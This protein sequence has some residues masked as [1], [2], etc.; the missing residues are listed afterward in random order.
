MATV[1]KMAWRSIWRNKRRTIISLISIAFGLGLAIFFIT[2]A[3]GAYYQVVRDAVKMQ[4]GYITIEHKGYLDAPAVDMFVS[5]PESILEPVRKLNLIENIKL[6]IVGGGVAKSGSGSVGVSFLGV[7]P[8]REVK[9][10]P[11]AKKIIDGQFL[12][13]EDGNLIIVGAVLAKRLKLQIGKK[14]V[15]STNDINGELVEELCRVKGIFKTGSDETDGQ[16]VL[17]PIGFARKLTS[18]PENAATQIGLMLRN[19]DQLKLAHAKVSKLVA[20]DQIEVLT[21]N[22]V[23]P[24]LAAYIKMDRTSGYIFY[25]IIFALVL[26]SIFNTI[27]M[28]VMERKHEFAIFLAI[29]TSPRQLEAQVVMESAYLGLLGSLLG[30]LIGYLISNY[31]AVNGWDLSG[32]MGGEDITVSG[33]A[34]STIIY[35]RITASVLIWC[36]LIVF[37]STVLLSF[38]PM[39]RASNVPFSDI[40]R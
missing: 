2:F 37:V 3:N 26:F 38:F 4:A 34:M 15:L 23:M 21:W 29:G 27:L 10:S 24:D 17:V 35:N 13:D 40:L 12:S 22:E 36:S 39:R 32:M 7:E 33:S 25:V 20:N 1:S 6:I 14:L 30:L 31:F 8:S 9:T 18:M 19:P 28:S 11:I 16:F 5:D